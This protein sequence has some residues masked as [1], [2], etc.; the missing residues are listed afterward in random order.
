MKIGWKT[1][2]SN[3]KPDEIL[4][5]IDSVKTVGA[6]GRVSFSAFDYHDAFASLFS[7]IELP[8]KSEELNLDSILSRSISITA[9]KGELTKDA[10][11]ENIR[12]FCK[13]ELATREEVY[14]FLT[15]ASIHP[16][17]PP[18]KTI[19]IE[20]AKITF[21]PGD[22][23]KKYQSRIQALAPSPRLSHEHENYCK[24]KIKLKAKSD[25]GATNKALR[26]FDI[27]RAVMALFSNSSME[28]M[29]NRHAPI[30][31]IRLGQ[32]HTLHTSNGKPAK[33]SV[34]FEPH[35]D[36]DKVYKPAK[37]EVFSYNVE[38]TMAR[39]D[40]CKY[41]KTIKDALLRYVRALDERDHNSALIRL[42]GA[43]ECLASPSDSNK[44]GITRRCAFLFEE[45]DYHQ[46]V[47]E[48]LREYRNQSV[49]AGEESDR[50]KTYCYQIQFYFR[51]LVLF[52]LRRTSEFQCLAEANQFLDLPTKP[53]DLRKKIELYQKALKFQG[54]P[55][56]PET[57]PM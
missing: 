52:H 54:G 1:K 26:S 46:Q 10:L 35:F 39:L 22:Y 25:Q 33:A 2:N 23:P 49:H 20:D 6:D 8:P 34:W 48:H 32:A 27:L 11:M 30:N 14:F 19:N 42:W 3:L 57:D 43:L 45:S 37:P 7:M 16:S 17:H 9:S 29:G 36:E 41:R 50:S 18:L 44:D 31:K 40:E 15:S 4:K 5:K 56:T 47:L 51:E 55:D 24:I 28:L 12:E 21:L 13:N 38:W 53:S